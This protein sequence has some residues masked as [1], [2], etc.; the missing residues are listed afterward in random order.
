MISSCAV[1]I[2]KPYAQEEATL[3]I[4]AAWAMHSAGGV[5]VTLILMGDGVFSVLGKS[6]Y[7]PSLYEQFISQDGAVYAVKEDLASRNVDE[8]LLPSNIA[9]LPAAEVSALVQDLDA[10]MSF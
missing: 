8:A 1:I 3:G 4:R 9:V 7:I 6:G 5:D 10:I 2:R